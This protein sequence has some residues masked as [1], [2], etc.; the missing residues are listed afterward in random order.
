MKIKTCA[1]KWKKEVANPY[2]PDQNDTI[3]SITCDGLEAGFQTVTAITREYL[4]FVK[5]T[6]NLPGLLPDLIGNDISDLMTRYRLKGEIRGDIVEYFPESDE[7]G[8][9]FIRFRLKDTKVQ[10]VEWISYVD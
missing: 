5:L 8:M 1:L 7:I 6:K 9:T 4:I 3:S 10:S 2:Y